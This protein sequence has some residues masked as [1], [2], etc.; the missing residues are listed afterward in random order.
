[1]AAHN[2]NYMYNM[3][4]LYGDAND[5]NNKYRQAYAQ[6]LLQEGGQDAA[7]QQQALAQQQ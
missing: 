6:A 2:N 5:V 1:M 7:R 3:A 4:K